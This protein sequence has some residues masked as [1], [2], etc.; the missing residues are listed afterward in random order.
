MCILVGKVIVFCSCIKNDMVINNNR[1]IIN[2]VTII[3]VRHYYDFDKR[4][5]RLVIKIRHNHQQQCSE[6]YNNLLDNIINFPRNFTKLAMI[7]TIIRG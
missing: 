7:S 1:F 4:I 6:N 3:F 2:S 5:T